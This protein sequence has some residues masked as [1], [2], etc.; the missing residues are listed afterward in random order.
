MT[1]GK[2]P[3]KQRLAAAGQ[4]A[5]GGQPA[6]AG[7]SRR[8]R[9]A[10]VPQRSRGRERVAALLSAA[11]QVINERGYDSA[12]MAEIAER[13]DAKIFSL[14]RFFPTKEVLAE[15]LL[16]RYAELYETAYDE[17]DA[18]ARTASTAELADLLIGFGARIR[19]QTPALTALLDARSEWSQKRMAFRERA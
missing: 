6:T 16:Q 3:N 19:E 18:Q 14:Y 11:A 17:I 4:P 2:R 15:A 7:Q 10:L 5:I 12:T 8:S 9:P 13:A 1:A